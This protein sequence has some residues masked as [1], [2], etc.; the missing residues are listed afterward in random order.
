MFREVSKR[1]NMKSDIRHES[2]AASQNLRSTI[3]NEGRCSREQAQT[4]VQWH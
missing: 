1:R 4:S 3:S 2:M